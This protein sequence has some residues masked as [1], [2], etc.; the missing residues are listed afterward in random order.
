[1][2]V[3][4]R[5]RSLM[6]VLRVSTK[7]AQAGNDNKV[8]E[9]KDF[10]ATRFMLE[11]KAKRC[12]LWLTR[13]GEHNPI[14]SSRIRY[15]YLSATAHFARYTMQA[16]PQH[17]FPT[18]PYAELQ[19]LLKPSSSNCG[20]RNPRSSCVPAFRASPSYQRMVSS[21]YAW[22]KSLTQGISLNTEMMYFIA[23]ACI[24]ALHFSQQAMFVVR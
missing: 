23:N 21:R 19:S 2:L 17:T 1:M 5:L 13:H 7:F 6:M 3:E 24:R 10:Q 12:I 20:L 9:L 8:Q 14:K 4:G 22:I 18:N 11:S 16:A 15:S